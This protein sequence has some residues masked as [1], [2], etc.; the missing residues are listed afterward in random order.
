MAVNI[1]DILQRAQTEGTPIIEDGKAIFVWHGETAPELVGD[2]NDWGRTISGVAWLE[3]QEQ[4]IWVYELKLPNDAYIEY[5][6]TR[7]P[8]DEDQRI[9]DKFNSKQVTNGLGKTNNYFSMPGRP[10]NALTEFVSGTPQ[11]HVTRHTISHPY[12]L[13][14]ERRT[15]WLYH[16]PTKVPVPLIVVYDGR[17][18]I[19]QGEITQILA[20]MIH[21]NLCAPVALAMVDNAKQGRFIEYNTS[22][23]TLRAVTDL[24]LPL[25]RGRMN[26]VN[27]DDH[28]GAY[29]V[30]GA[31][32][33]GLMALYSGLR[34]PHI[35]GKV[36]S[37]AGAYNLDITKVDPLI[38]KLAK[39]SSTKDIDVWMDVGSYDF[40]ID[41]NREMR[42]LLINKGYNVHYHEQSTGHNYTAWGDVLPQA[43]STM[44]PAE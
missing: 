4:D 38:Y 14:G 23:A 12:L 26:L 18:Y 35:F 19:R 28:P 7:D 40:L 32:M 2:F 33:G 25:A 36:I 44:F 10:Y 30:L 11:G 22:E 24:V 9:L 20:N 37:Q 41:S 27:V 6:F 21:Q 43:L 15:V 31:S 13:F 42:D 16:P 34:Q 8:D 1:Q 29:G 5:V 3:R 17:D 39:D